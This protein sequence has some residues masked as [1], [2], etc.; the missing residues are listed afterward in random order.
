MN[1][2][3]F[4]M[5]VGS[6]GSLI[7]LVRAFLLFPVNHVC[8]LCTRYN[9]H[10]FRRFKGFNFSPALSSISCGCTNWRLM[11]SLVPAVMRQVIRSSFPR[12]LCSTYILRLSYVAITFFVAVGFRFYVGL[13]RQCATGAWSPTL[14]R[15]L[16]HAPGFGIVGLR[17][18]A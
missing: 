1:A 8:E 10:G 6:S 7:R 5:V 15:R 18:F 11:R 13:R 16:F 12:D 3:C 14:H 4:L 2:C 17:E 9:T